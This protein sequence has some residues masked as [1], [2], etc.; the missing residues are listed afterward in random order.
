MTAYEFLIR[1]LGVW[2]LFSKWLRGIELTEFLS[3]YVVEFNI[4]VNRVD[5]N[6]I[7][8][9]TIQKKFFFLDIFYIL[10]P[11]ESSEM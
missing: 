9:F 1:F 2:G 6:F 3:K 8:C 11:E 5:L 4:I 10:S 7:W